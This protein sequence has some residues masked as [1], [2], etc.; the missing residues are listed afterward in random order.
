MSEEAV[1][2]VAYGF[3][4]LTEGIVHMLVNGVPVMKD[5]QF[6]HSS[7]GRPLKPEA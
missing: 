7:P 2:V 1:R 5:S 3:T 6:M 4:C